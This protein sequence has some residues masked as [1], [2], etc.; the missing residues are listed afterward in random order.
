MFQAEVLLSLAL[1]MITGTSLLATIFFEINHGR[2]DPLHVLLGEGFATTSEAQDFKGRPTDSGV[3][4]RFDREGRIVGLTDS[5]E[6][7]DSE[8]RALA[9]ESLELGEALIASSAAWDPIRF[10]APDESGESVLTGRIAAPVSGA[11]LAGLVVVDIL[12][13]GLCGITLLRRRIIGPL[14]RLSHAVR[15]I[16]E[17]GLPSSV[18]FDGV[19]EI[20]SLGIAFNDMQGALAS[21]TGRA[22]E[23]GSR[24]GDG[25]REPAPGT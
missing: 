14:H 6:T 18:P 9:T 11:V 21:R 8:T 17:G 1:V 15:E 7:L 4:W 16:G 5:S 13:F 3:W 2:I 20:E 12:V 23:S 24:P 19:G 22:R 25:E 10:A